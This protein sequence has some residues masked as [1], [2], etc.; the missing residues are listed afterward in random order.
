MNASPVVVGVGL[1]SMAP[2]KLFPDPRRSYAAQ[3]VL[4]SCGPG[5]PP[6]WPPGLLVHLPGVVCTD[7]SCNFSNSLDAY[8][9]A[10]HATPRRATPR[11]AELRYALL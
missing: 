11:H 3:M 1:D 4:W 10:P 7:R 8:D 5:R 2:M 9:G 6:L